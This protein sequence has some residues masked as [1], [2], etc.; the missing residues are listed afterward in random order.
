MFDTAS[1]AQYRK[2]HIKKKPINSHIRR[3]PVQPHQR[4]HIGLSYMMVAGTQ[5]RTVF[6]DDPLG[7]REEEQTRTVRTIGGYGITL[8][9]FFTFTRF[10]SN[11][12]ALTL[13]TDFAYNYLPWEELDSGFS[14]RAEPKEHKATDFT[15]QMGAPI[16]LDLK[17][18]AD[19]GPSFNHTWSAAVGAGVYPVIVFTAPSKKIFKEAH[20]ITQSPIPFIKLE[21]GQ[22]FWVL[23]KVRALLMFGGPEYIPKGRVYNSM[24]G[25]YSLTGKF[26]AN[27]S[28]LVY[29]F[30]YSWPEYGWWQP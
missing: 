9:S 6:Y 25:D 14:Y 10:N 8:G 17:L 27:I 21:Y 16:S 29:P 13:S 23:M 26:G 7:I 15:I 4:M 22:R 18:G 24:S 3:S 19:A 5:Q 12:A 20:Y 2:A 28:L 11:I 30:S 1:L